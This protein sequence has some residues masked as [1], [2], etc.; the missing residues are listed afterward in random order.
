M[1]QGKARTFLSP[2]KVSTFL[3]GGFWEGAGTQNC[4]AGAGWL[5]RKER[6]EPR[7]SLGENERVKVYYCCLMLMRSQLNQPALA[8]CWAHMVALRMTVMMMTMI[9]VVV[10]IILR[11]KI[12]YQ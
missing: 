3:R 12:C 8:E 2:Q 9:V 1:I 10:T 11:L 4:L 5:V 6:R 7:K